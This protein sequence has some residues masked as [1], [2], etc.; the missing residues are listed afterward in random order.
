MAKNDTIFPAI[1]ISVFDIIVPEDKLNETLFENL[2]GEQAAEELADN[3]A[4]TAFTPEASRQIL[5]GLKRFD[6]FPDKHFEMLNALD[7]QDQIADALEARAKR[8]CEDA[9]DKGWI[10]P[11]GGLVV[12]AQ[13]YA[14]KTNAY[15]RDLQDWYEH[16]TFVAMRSAGQHVE[17]NRFLLREDNEANGVVAASIFYARGYHMGKA[18]EITALT[19]E[20]EI[21]LLMPGRIS[22]RLMP[23]T[24]PLE[25]I[26]TVAYCQRHPQY[27]QSPMMGFP[28][29][30]GRQ[31]PP[32]Q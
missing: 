20:S 13:D 12:T 28:A 10:H 26:D 30:S 9:I 14:N 2:G 17:T 19:N 1:H 3:M 29:G 16:C 4:P 8:A 21:T 31:F 18:L 22:I 24:L 32:P 15:V 11:R 6:D 5:S 27:R 7:R 25:K 23:G